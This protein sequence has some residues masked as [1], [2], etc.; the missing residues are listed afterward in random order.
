MYAIRSY[1]GLP[2]PLFAK[3]VAEGTSKGVSAKSVLRRAEDIRP[4]CSE[5]LATFRQPV[6]LEGFLPGREFTV[7]IVGTGERAEAIGTLEV[8]LLAGA[9]QGAYSY[10]YNF[11]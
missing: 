3:P 9:E 7:G 4:V 10:S 11:V 2:L 5:L 6:L 8:L 1:Y